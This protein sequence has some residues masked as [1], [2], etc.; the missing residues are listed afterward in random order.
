MYN[1]SQ[2]WLKSDEKK[3]LPLSWWKP[4]RFEKWATEGLKI[5]AMAMNVR[6][7]IDRIASVVANTVPKR[8]PHIGGDEQSRIPADDRDRHRPVGDRGVNRREPG[9]AFRWKRSTR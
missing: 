1:V 2:P 6:G 7:I 9:R 5:Q 3:L 4:D 8:S